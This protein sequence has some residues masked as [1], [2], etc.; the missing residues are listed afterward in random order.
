MSSFDDDGSPPPGD[1]TE[2]YFT[3]YDLSNAPHPP[4]FA[5]LYGYNIETLQRLIHERLQFTAQLLQRAPTATETEALVEHTAKTYT[6]GSLGPPIIALCGLGRTWQTAG[7]MRFPF[8]RPSA[9]A[10]EGMKAGRVLGVEMGR[11]GPVVWHGLRGAAYAG[12]WGLVGKL[13]FPGYVAVW[14]V[15]GERADARLGKVWKAMEEEAGR[16]LR[17]GRRPAGPPAEGAD[18][19]RRQR[20]PA[21]RRPPQPPLDPLPTDSAL[22]SG[23]R[24]LSDAD[25]LLQD[26]QRRRSAPE[27][28]T[29][30]PSPPPN[31][32]AQPSTTWSRIR[33]SA[34]S[35]SPSAQPTKSAW[36]R[37]REAR[38]T[39]PSDGEEKAESREEAQREFDERVEQERRGEGTD[40]AG[41]WGGGRGWN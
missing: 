32:Q 9:E 1:T 18:E 10:A 3:P 25:M 34:I 7:D 37:A 40:G 8:W 2:T 36:H 4:S 35:S 15:A 21:P 33:A 24:L 22:D 11:L 39:G 29:T 38:D 20:S 16:K 5:R 28:S 26:E 13:V 6:R 31:P 23:D 30:L 14:A 19:Q 17:R 27:S 41:S 12:L